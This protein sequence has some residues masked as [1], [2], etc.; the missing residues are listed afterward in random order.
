MSDIIIVIE[1]LPDADSVYMAL[2]EEQKA[3]LEALEELGALAPDIYITT[4]KIEVM[5]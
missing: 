2:N 3:L 5:Y 4:P 1:N